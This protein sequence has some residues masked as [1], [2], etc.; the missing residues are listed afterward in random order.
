MTHDQDEPL[1]TVGIPTY[2]RPDMLREAIDSALAQTYRNT[3]ILVSDS[4]ADPA[5]AALVESYRDPRL[6]YRH[7]GGVSDGS[8]NAKAMYQAATGDL[9]AT[10]H[11]DDIWEPHFLELLVPPLVADPQVVVS[12]GDFAVMDAD[13]APRP[14]I[15][16]R[17]HD[18][19][20]L[21]RGRY[22]PFYDL[23]TSRRAIPM[24]I[25]AV[26]RASAIDWAD[27]REEAGIADDLWM[28]YLL[29][30]DG[31]AAWY[32]PA[33]VSRYRHHPTATS[34]VIRGDDGAIWCYEQ[35]LAD[36]RM[37]S[38]HRDLR[39]AAA[40]RYTGRALAELS[41]DAPG[42][43]RRAARDL[44]VA[45]RDGRTARTARTAVACA[46]WPLPGPARSWVITTAGRVRS[47]RRGRD[48]GTPPTT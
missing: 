15:D 9:I 6:R 42:A 26:F 20:G 29:A 1:V 38:V 8:T 28:A 23:A 16:A 19:E 11:D 17:N 18:R 44:R 10:L 46:L 37:A 25:T 35:M 45:L 30:R 22:Q 27:W 32:E 13:G 14:D 24:A 43:R 31:G 12:F 33:R 41:G 40:A 5:I 47:R 3:E 21:R 48:A 2:R 39:R 36:D 34:S 7:N 4:A